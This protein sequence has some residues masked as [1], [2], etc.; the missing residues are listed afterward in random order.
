MLCAIKLAKGSAAGTIQFHIKFNYFR[1]HESP[2]NRLLLETGF[3]SINFLTQHQSFQKHE[4]Y[5]FIN[6]LH[7]TVCNESL[8]AETKNICTNYKVLQFDRLL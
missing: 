1:A 3:N 8:L 7:V 5:Q 6:L 4:K 2:Y